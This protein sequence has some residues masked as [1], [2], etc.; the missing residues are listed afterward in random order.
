MTLL[1][2]NYGDIIQYG[3]HPRDDQLP[4]TDACI[5]LSGLVGLFANYFTNI[6]Y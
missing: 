2:G 1:K 6:S 3:H 5:V 4:G